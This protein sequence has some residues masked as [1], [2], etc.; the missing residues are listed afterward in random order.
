MVNP[1]F[2]S[3]L[4]S[5]QSEYLVIKTSCQP[6]AP[7]TPQEAILCHRCVNLN[8]IYLPDQFSTPGF[9]P[10][11]RLILLPSNFCEIQKN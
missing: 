4:Y 11:C 6:N 10:W 5:Q 3:Y 8:K 9:Q 1:Y 7:S 2:N